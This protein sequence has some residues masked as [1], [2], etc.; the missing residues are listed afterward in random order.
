VQWSCWL[1]MWFMDV[2]TGLDCWL[3]PSL[4]SKHG[5]FSN[6]KVGHQRKAFLSVLTQRPL[7]FFLK[8][9]LS[10]A[11][12]TYI[13]CLGIRGLQLLGVVI[14]SQIFEIHLHLCSP[15]S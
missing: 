10:L 3:P 12:R 15:C 2:M 13:P 8:F 4:G 7:S 14:L 1:L 6:I 11:I 9:M 5:S